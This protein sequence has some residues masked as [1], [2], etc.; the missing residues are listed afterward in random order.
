MPDHEATPVDYGD[1]CL[2]YDKGWFAKN[3][4]A[5]PTS[6][7]DLTKPAYKG[8]LVVEDASASSPGLAFLLATVARFGDSEY[9]DYWKALR[10]NGVKVADS[11]D[12]AYYDD[13]TAPAAA[14]ASA[15]SS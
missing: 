8:R 6:L 15:R 14:P 13:F 2:N 1:V 4:I 5:L 11:W 10:A 9:I 7:D 3:G 12:T